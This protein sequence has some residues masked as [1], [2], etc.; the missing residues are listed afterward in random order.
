MRPG[1]SPTVLSALVTGESLEQL[2]RGP[3]AG[4]SNPDPSTGS[5]D[6]LL[7]LGGGRDRKVR[8][9]QEADLDLLRGGCGGRPSSDPGGLLKNKQIQDSCC[10]GNTAG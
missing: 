3:A 1:P 4:T 9:L 2:R 8:D 7:R 10:L 6:Q 5:T